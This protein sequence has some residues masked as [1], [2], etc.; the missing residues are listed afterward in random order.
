MCTSILPRGHG[1]PHRIN[2]QSR[3][4]VKWN[5]Q[6][7]KQRVACIYVDIRAVAG[8]PASQGWLRGGFVIFYEQDSGPDLA[9]L[10]TPLT[11]GGGVPGPAELRCLFYALIYSKQPSERKGWKFQSE[12]LWPVIE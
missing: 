10:G 12:Y 8:P 6:H 2:I 7:R 5:F 1:H 11:L 3:A 4:F 9:G